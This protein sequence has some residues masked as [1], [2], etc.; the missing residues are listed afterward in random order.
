MGKYILNDR[1]SIIWQISLVAFFLLETTG[2]YSGFQIP[3]SLFGVQ[4]STVE[5]PSNTVNFQAGSFQ[6][7]FMSSSYMSTGH[8]EELTV[9]K[10]EVDRAAAAGYTGVVVWDSNLFYAGHPDQPGQPPHDMSTFKQGMDY[11]LS[12]NLKVIPEIMPF[13]Y[14]HEILQTD[15]NFAEAQRVVGSKFLVV[16]GGPTGLTLQF[17]NTLPA[18]ANSG[19]ESDTQQQWFDWGDTRTQR[20]TDFAHSGSHS[21]KIV[22]GTNCCA[23][24]AQNMNLTPWRLYHL[25]FFLKTEGLVGGDAVHI[26]INDYKDKNHV[27]TRID[28]GAP[29]KSTQDWTQVDFTFNSMDSTSGILLIG[30][31]GNQQGTIWIDDITVQETALVNLVRRSGTPVKIYDANNPSITFSENSDVTPIVDPLMG[32]SGAVGTFDYYH[33]PP[34]I[35]VPAGS[36]LKAGQMIVIDHYAAQPQTAA[37]QVGACLTEQKVFDWVKVNFQALAPLFPAGTT[38]LLAYDEMR[39]M[40]SC[41]SCKAK[42]MTAGQ[43]LAWH[44]QQVVGIIKGIDP[45]LQ[46]MVWNDMFD[47]YHNAVDQYYRVEGT[48]A[49]SWNGLGPDIGVLNWNLQNLTK[50]LNFFAGLDPNYPGLSAHY[51]VISGFYDKGDPTG[52]AIR[53]GTSA[54]GIP[55]VGGQSYTTWQY[56]YGNDM[57]LYITGVNSVWNNP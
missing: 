21:G 10:N 17:Q 1:T 16:P 46:V 34:T 28:E 29:Y 41:G 55:G 5:P 24:F 56:N 40:N 11:A 27:V 4:S 6:K 52:E 13:G 50:S 54:Q 33:S 30:N 37:M 35:N 53:E 26:Y 20:V 36:R 23:R 32:K 43:L 9:F 39:E 31:W 19:F 45:K 48:I 14:S 18:L 15:P 44:L 25:Q 2:C 22:P 42:N 8:P 51:Q 38:Y 12:K 7:L 49:G 47:P 57:N 3:T